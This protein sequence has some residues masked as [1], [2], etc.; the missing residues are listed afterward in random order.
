MSLPPVPKYTNGS[1][2]SPRPSSSSSHH[3]TLLIAVANCWFVMFWYPSAISVGEIDTAAQTASGSVSA[4]WSMTVGS[5]CLYILRSC[6][7][8]WHLYWLGWDSKRGI[9][10]NDFD[11]SSDTRLTRRA[12]SKFAVLL[13]CCFVVGG[14]LLWQMEVWHFKSEL[15]GPPGGEEGEW[16]RLQ[17]FNFWIEAKIFFFVVPFR[18]VRSKVFCTVQGI[19]WYRSLFRLA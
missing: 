17:T 7:N 19:K 13:C 10:R 6:W 11:N 9:D 15:P 12:L 14:K 8:W 1:V 18:H 3:A 5:S 2:M 4:F 16:G